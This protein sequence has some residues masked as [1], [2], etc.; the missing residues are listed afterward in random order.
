MEGEK[1]EQEFVVRD[2]RIS[3]SGTSD[4]SSEPKAK[5]SEKGPSNAERATEGSTEQKRTGPLP[6]LDF[7]SFILSL[8]TTAQVSLGNIP[9]PQTNQPTQN[10]P[11]AKQMIDMLG[12]LKDKTKGNL[13]EDE[14]GLLD[15]V[16]FNLRMQYVRAAEGKKT[17][18]KK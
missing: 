1:K 14:Q 9:D 6:E 12:M 17:E 5:Q 7:P 13:T 15:S 16:L 4:D 3:S 11:V 18:D 2:R 8:A 10:L